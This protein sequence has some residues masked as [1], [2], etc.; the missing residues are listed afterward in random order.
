MDRHTVIG[1]SVCSR[2]SFFVRQPP[3]E[4]KTHEELLLRAKAETEQI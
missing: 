3:E 2:L 4:I 1:D